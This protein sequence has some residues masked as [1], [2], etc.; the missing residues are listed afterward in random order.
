MTKQR[1]KSKPDLVPSI[2]YVAGIVLLVFS[3]L[4]SLAL[5]ISHITGLG[6]L[7]CGKGSACA[8]AAASVWGKV[9]V[10]GW[11]VAFLGVAYFLAAAVAWILSRQGVSSLFRNLVRLGAAISALFMA[12]IVI[13]GHHCSYCIA[14]HVG[15]FIF[16]ILMER[17]PR[18]PSASL[19]P[20]LALVMV[21]L[22]SSAV[23]GFTELQKKQTVTAKQEQDFT[24]S[25]DE[26]II[27]AV[28]E[29]AVIAIEG[30]ETPAQTPEKTPDDASETATKSSPASTTESTSPWGDA[31]FTGRWLWGKEKE[32]V[33]LV[34]YTDYQCTDCYRIEGEIRAS[35]MN[36]EGVSVSI[37][38]FPMCADCNPDFKNRNMHANACWAAR[39]AEAAGILRGNDGFWE[40]H[41]WLFDQKGSF[42]KEELNKGLRDFGYDPAE[43]IKVMM[44]DET[45]KL[46]QSDI[47][48]GIWLGLHFTPMVFVNGIQ[49]RG[50][51]IKDGVRKAVDRILAVNPPAMT[52][53]ADNP[54][55]AVEK[56][57]GDWRSQRVVRMP[58][59]T[60]SWSRGP[61]DAKVKIVVWAD[62][63]EVY[64]VKADTIIRE[65]IGDRADVQYSFRH[66][67]F[68]QACNPVVSRTAHEHACLA[69]KAVEAAGILGGVDGY[70][71]MHEW[72]MS[73]RE[74][75]NEQLLY[76]SAPELGFETDAFLAAMENPEVAA[77]IE[78]DSRSGKR[79]LYRGGIPTIYVNGQV[80]PRWRRGDSPILKMILDEAYGKEQ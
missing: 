68:N 3:A 63:Q 33:R 30:E 65:W 77:A 4:M 78:E 59:D 51:F 60:H 41:H 39:A 8:E 58:P 38:H 53:A 74:G 42:T 45:L 27:A 40:M 31:P 15:N 67:P 62:Y 34:L 36:R 47:E 72:L 69:A 50:I 55:P 20:L 11:P 66:F 2:S 12:V 75:L 35:L 10:I 43:F 6:L 5:S 23:L 49:L 37:K 22:L 70:W 57:I 25:T 56:C 48:E 52:A 71:R 21:F 79:R 32:K 16:W 24:E 54:P 26:I 46:V 19:R 18:R 44:G 14:S 9:P 29:P 61:D 28:Q 64:S 73:N 1:K 13:E 80:L 17:T 7:G 76:L